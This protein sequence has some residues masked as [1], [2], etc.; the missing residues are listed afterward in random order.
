MKKFLCV[1]LM[2]CVMLTA[3]LAEEAPALNWE[4]FVP[5]LEAA[6]VS[7]EFYT[8]EEIAVK[9]WVPEGLKPVE[10]TE[11]D[12]AKGYIGY[13]MP[14]DQTAQMAVM[15]VDVNGM[16]MEEY[17]GYL[18]GV[19]GVSEIEA[20]TVNGLPCV[21]YKIAGQDSV[22][23]TFATEAGYALEITC[24]PLSEENAELVWGAV[25]GSIQ[26]AE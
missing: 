15:Y 9:I 18:S 24:A 16:S 10:L 13:F 17:A 26:A 14:D 22:S 1:V 11:E 3:A 20:G 5:V 6:N 25:I 2:L 8:F 12:K 4:T 7:G 23:V 19:E 21:T